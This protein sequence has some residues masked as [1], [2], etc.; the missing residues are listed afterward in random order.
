MKAIVSVHSPYRSTENDS[1]P[2]GARS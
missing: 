1:P 2:D